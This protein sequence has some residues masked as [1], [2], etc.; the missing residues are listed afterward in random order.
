MHESLAIVG[1]RDPAGRRLDLTI[2]EGLLADEGMTDATFDATELTIAP[3]FIDLQVNGAF[4]CDFTTDPESMWDAAARLPET[5]VT[6][7][8]PTLITAP[9]GTAREAQI[10]LGHRPDGFVGAEPIGLHVEGPMLSFAMRGAHP[11]QYLVD[12]ASAHDWSPESGIALVTLA[13]ELPGAP[14][15]IRTLTERG[16][17]VSLGHSNASC[18]EAQAGADAGATFGT[19][20]FNAMSLMSSREPGLAGFLLTDP[21]MRFGVINDGVHLHRRIVE[22]IW[23]DAG[24]R[25]ILVTDAIAA[26]GV[27]DG[28]Y[29][30]G[31]LEITVS[32]MAAIR[33]D[34]GL[35][36]SVLT[37]DRAVRNLLAITGCTLDQAIAAATA[38]PASLMGLSDRGTLRIGDRA[39]LVLLDRDANVAA[40]MVF[41]RVVHIVEPDRLRGESH[42]PA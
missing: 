32:G 25:M 9:D 15:A 27:G 34:G 19:H 14:E 5:G 7:F 24:D 8:L 23:A 4:G 1:G 2:R 11:P 38:Q 41:G 26:M 6:G 30:L 3:G 10:A 29:R 16:V 13:P 37:M 12:R 21:K 35:G 42:V 17:V 36:G 20:L 22:L 31:S 28:T 33:A 18:L 39:D 40:T